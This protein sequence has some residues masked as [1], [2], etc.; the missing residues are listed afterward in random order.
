MVVVVVVV[1]IM[2][3]ATILVMMTPMT[4]GENEYVLLTLQKVG[5]LGGPSYM[6][7]RW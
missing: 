4:T 1:V 5:V 2:M 3:A 6:W 7:W